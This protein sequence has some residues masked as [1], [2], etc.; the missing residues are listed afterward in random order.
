[1]A[2]YVLTDWPVMQALSRAAGRGAKVRISLDAPR[3]N[4]AMI[5][6]LQ[7]FEPNIEARRSKEMIIY[8]EN[9]LEGAPDGCR[10]G[11][12]RTGH[13]NDRIFRGHV[14]LLF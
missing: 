7:A 6:L 12:G 11:P 10:S 1:M 8:T 2:A 3:W 5:A 14:S 13:R 4:L 9:L